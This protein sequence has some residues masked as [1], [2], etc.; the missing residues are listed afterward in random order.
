MKKLKEKG[1]SVFERIKNKM[2]K[3]HMCFK[4]MKGKWGKV[5]F[6]V[7]PL[8]VAAV[9][10]GVGIY[11][12]GQTKEPP[13]TVEVVTNKV[14]RRVYLVS[15][16]E[17]TIPLTVGLTKRD[18]TQEEM[19][20]VFALLKEDSKA[21]TG[22][23]KGLIP[24]ETKLNSLEL[25]E[26]ELILDMS[27]DFLNYKANDESKLLESI[28]YTYSEFPDVNMISLYIDGARLEKLPKN[29]TAVTMC[30]STSIGINRESKKAVDVTGKQM[31][32]VYYQ[33]AIDN[34]NYL[35]PVSQ[36]VD[37]KDSLE[38]QL[39]NAV[40]EPLDESRGLKTLTDYSLVSQ[41]QT[42]TD[43]TKF[44]L[45]LKD[46]ALKEEGVV[47]RSLYDLVSLTM[48]DLVEAKEISFVI[49]EEEMM[50]EGLLDPEVYEVSNYIYNQVEI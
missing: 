31:I 12:T 40:N 37:K 30:L 17:L 35:V 34:R 29:N 41:I 26:N 25:F 36:Y 33:K 27:A 8:V 19:V 18:T 15:A 4:P 11:L 45:N 50:V 46:A 42:N 44:V 20:E 10:A 49:E 32:N 23:I 43:K 6:V 21:N 5:A 14:N 24:K 48:A 47:K 39:V 7:V 22:T 2:P 3:V 28:V 13:K 16:D 38:V 9:G 1:P